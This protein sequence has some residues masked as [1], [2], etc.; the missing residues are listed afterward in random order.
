[1]MNPQTGSTYECPQC[2]ERNNIKDRVCRHCHYMN[3]Y[4]VPDAILSDNRRNDQVFRAVSLLI[5]GIVSIS[6]FVW[7]EIYFRSNILSA[8]IQVSQYQSDC[9][10]SFVE[11]AKSSANQ[12]RL[13]GGDPY[14][15][16]LNAHLDDP[17]RIESV[18]GQFADISTSRKSHV[19]VFRRNADRIAD[20]HDFS[21]VVS[22]VRP[23]CDTMFDPAYLEIWNGHGT[24]V[25]AGGLRYLLKA[26]PT[27]IADQFRVMH[28]LCSGIIAVL[29]VL[30]GI[31][32]FVPTRRRSEF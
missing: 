2:G 31:G 13:L 5:V 32:S 17:C 1:M 23:P 24:A 12:A 27:V 30:F 21:V 3:P 16:Y 18:S 29:T 6:L 15:E 14:F 10:S 7:S 8:D 22:S 26:N 4:R 25:T 11:A 19:Y 28:G 20:S 9:S